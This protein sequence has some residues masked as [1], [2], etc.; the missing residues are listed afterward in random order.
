[1]RVRLHP[2][3]AMF[4]STGLQRTF[5]HELQHLMGL[6]NYADA[7]ACGVSDAAMQDDF[8]CNGTNALTTLTINDILP[9]AKTS[10]GGG[11][12]TACGF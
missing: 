2:A 6:D 1:M 4:T 3:W 8:D 12:R 5:V 9:A 11:P 10:Y 7:P